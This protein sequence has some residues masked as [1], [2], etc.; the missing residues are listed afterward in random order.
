VQRDAHVQALAAVVDVVVGVEALVGDAVAVVVD[1]VAGLD[2]AVGL[3]ARHLAA[4]RGP[5][6]VE[7]AGAQA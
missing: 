7:E 5:T 4:G 1:A 6:A 3:D 2:A